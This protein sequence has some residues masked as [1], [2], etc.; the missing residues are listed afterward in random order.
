MSQY[1]SGQTYAP[2]TQKSHRSVPASGAY[3]ISAVVL[4]ICILIAGL[5]VGG[6]LRSLNKTIAEKSFES[7]YNSPDKIT[8]NGTAERKYLTQDEAAAYLNITVSDIS[9]AIADGK[10]EDYIITSNGYSIS[11]AALDDYFESEAYEIKMKKNGAE[12]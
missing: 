12:N 10:I 11:I 2:Q 3:M 7:T 4:G 6:A 5:N 8:V 9:S 1:R